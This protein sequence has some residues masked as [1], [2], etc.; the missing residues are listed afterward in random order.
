MALNTESF[1]IVL[2]ILDGKNWERWCIQMKAILGYQDVM[3][4]MEEGYLSLPERATEA[5]KAI[6]KENK[7]WDY[8]AMCLFH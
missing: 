7:K 5:Q 8:K 1:A 3:D 2:P 6:H 4:I